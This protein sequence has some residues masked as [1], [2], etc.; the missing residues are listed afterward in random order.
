[1]EQE[2][3]DS[4]RI[5][6]KRWNRSNKG[7]QPRHSLLETLTSHRI[8][9]LLSIFGK[10]KLTEKRAEAPLDNM[11]ITEFFKIIN[12]EKTNF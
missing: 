3:R 9:R 4:L 8:K 10:G 1:M 7:A 5:A 6:L 2:Q 11:Y 12:V